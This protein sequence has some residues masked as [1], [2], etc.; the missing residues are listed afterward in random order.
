[1][2]A[3]SIKNTDLLP[4]VKPLAN[5]YVIF[6]FF[7]QDYYITREEAYNVV[8]GVK[9]VSLCKIDVDLFFPLRS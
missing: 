9:Y 2:I 4:N 7:M 3:N 6:F 5:N 1:M 8:Y